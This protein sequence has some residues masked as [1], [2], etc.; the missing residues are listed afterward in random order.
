M[1]LEKYLEAAEVINKAYDV[2]ST[3]EP[4][5][6]YQY[7]FIFDDDITAVLKSLHIYLT[8]KAVNPKLKVVMVGGEGLL[9][10]AFKVMRFSH[11][12]QGKNLALECL[13]KETE[14][15][16]LKRVALQLGIPESDIIVADNGHNTTEN[17]QAMSK[18][19]QGQK[20]VVVS[21]QRLAMIFKQSAQFQCNEYP[22]IF[23]CE[24]FDFDIYVIHQPVFCTF[25]WYN[26]QRAGDGRVAFHFY[27][28]LVQR[29]ELDDGKFL[30]KPF[31]PDKKTKKADAILRNRFLIKRRPTGFKKFRA[32]LQYIPILWSIF[33]NATEYII[34]EKDA[35]NNAPHLS[36]ANSR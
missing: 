25:H 13:K 3:F 22:K 12:V 8:A 1:E 32:M 29:F 23:G 30:R 14:A 10:F 9:A 11:W 19:A 2:R 6:K 17:L 33:L 5:R 18:I 21:T 7:M 31:E 35:I 15:E 16:R 4:K 36:R 24:P 34:D 27:A 26:F 28:S 20:S